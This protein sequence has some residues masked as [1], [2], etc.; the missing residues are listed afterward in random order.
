MMLTW[1]A[2]LIV[3]VVGGLLVYWHL[4]GTQI[5][6]PG[7]RTSEGLFDGVSGGDQPSHGHDGGGSGDGD[8]GASH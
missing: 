1:V 5:L 4:S 6:A 8:A 2:I 7:R 3:V